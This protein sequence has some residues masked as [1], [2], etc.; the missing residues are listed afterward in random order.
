VV[1]DGECGALR[2]V[3]DVEA[4]AAAAIDLLADDDKRRAYGAAGRRRAVD[5]F[6]EA[7]VVA[8]YRS[9]YERVVSG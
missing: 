8:Q 3:G 9:I 5:V 4:M 1:V 6:G 2:P 7:R